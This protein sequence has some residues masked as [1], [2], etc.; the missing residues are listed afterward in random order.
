MNIHPQQGAMGSWRDGFAADRHKVVQILTQTLK[1]TQPA[2]Y[3]ANKAAQLAQE[4]ENF[5]FQ[6]SQSRDDYMISIKSKIG[7]FK[8]SVN[9]NGMQQQQQQQQQNTGLRQPQQQQPNVNAPQ[10]QQGNMN[11]QNMNFLQRQAQARQQSAAQIQAQLRN[12][13]QQ[14]QQPQAQQPQQN[15]FQ[16]SIQQQQQQTQQIPPGGAKPAQPQLNQ[17]QLIRIGNQLRNAPIP[18]ALLSK[19]PNLPPNVNTLSQIIECIQN[20]I[21]PSSVTQLVKDIHNTHVQL[22]VRQQQQQQQQNVNLMQAN[23]QQMQQ[24]GLN[25]Q[26][27]VNNANITSAL[28]NPNLTAQQKQQYQRQLQ[29]QQQQQQQ[30]APSVVNGGPQQQQQFPQSQIPPG[31]QMRNQQQTA[32]QMLPQGQNQMQSQIQPQGGQAQGQSNLAN[33]PNLKITPQDM[34]KYSPDA[35]SM[36]TK[37]Q[38]RGEI[39]R[40]LNMNQKEEFIKKYI[41]HHKNLLWKQQNE[42]AAN[43]GTI[44]GANNIGG[45]APQQQLQPQHQQQ[46]N[47]AMLNQSTMLN[48]NIPLQQQS[49]QQQQQQQQQMQPKINQSMA[50]FNNNTSP[51]LPFNGLNQSMQPRVPIPSQN[52]NSNPNSNQNPIPNQNHLQQ[53]PIPQ[54]RNNFQ[55]QQ[56]Q[57]QQQQNRA[58]LNNQPGGQQGNQP[59]GQ[60]GGAQARPQAVL[61][62]VTDDV[63][64]KL[65][66]LVESVSRHHVALK[67][68]TLTLSINEKKIVRDSIMAISQQY[69]SVDSI[70]TYFYVTTRNADGTTKL[71][72]MKYMTKNIIESLQRGI[73]LATPD[74]LDK[75]RA[76]Y[77]KYFEYVKDQIS[78]RRQQMQVQQQQLQQMSSVNPPLA[79]TQAQ[80]LQQFNNIQQQRA[81]AIQRGGQL[82]P[83]QPQG[84]QNWNN[85]PGMVGQQQQQMQKNQQPPMHSSPM[86]PNGVSPLISNANLAIQQ[87]V[88]G[89]NNNKVSPQK[90]NARMP[91]GNLLNNNNN[92]NNNLKKNNVVPPAARRK[93]SKGTSAAGGMP[94]PVGGNATTPGTLANSIKTPNSISTPMI[95]P[96]SQGSN[97]NTPIE[98]PNYHNKNPSVSSVSSTKQLNSNNALTQQQQLQLIQ[99]KVFED[100]LVESPEVNAKLLARKKLASSDSEK[101]FFA[102]LANMLDLEEGTGENKIGNYNGSSG[103]KSLPTPQSM[104]NGKIGSAM[105]PLSPIS[106]PLASSSSFGFALALGNGLLLGQS[107]G[108][109]CEIK[110]EAITSTFNQIESIKDLTSSDIIQTCYRIGE[111][112]KREREQQQ[113]KQESENSLKH[114]RD[115]N[116]D[117]DD[118]FME[119]KKPKFDFEDISEK[120]LYQHNDFE[121]WKDFVIA[122]ED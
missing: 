2:N 88:I 69:A 4:F 11:V 30:R 71:I 75:L 18:Q 32:P 115:D 43:R 120:F 42:L 70:I 46:S 19:I 93:S 7:Q 35:L 6:K 38:E 62:V 41:V 36:L 76:Q 26:A 72:Q 10:Q 39:T 119:E 114:P 56:Q 47:Q 29:Q 64:L 81:N 107:T 28:N 45:N 22:V 98:S 16:Q 84:N 13:N 65:R 57:L 111:I 97:K 66:Q 79:P 44:N 27:S 117:F 48:Q 95:P 58:P 94:T 54:N 104:Y 3:D 73:Y 90:Q 106:L 99:D 50:Q 102:S 112:E 60:A 5:T 122:N 12:K 52:P 51:V 91:Q 74:L 24:Q 78:N 55:Q 34:M 59:G 109:T 14:Q 118:L 40:N 92:N 89:N 63:K 96:Q 103:G 21:I 67:D 33:G 8:A 85:A 61:P 121:D 105:S 110:P 108:W 37:L 113:I 68:E 25:P 23:L 49:Q 53:Q 31:Q 80:P 82:P 87:P 100:S 83:Q 1:D 15:Q 9:R 20:G 17:Q 86:M 101:F 77:Q 116:N